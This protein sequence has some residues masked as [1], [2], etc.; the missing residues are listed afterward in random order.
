MRKCRSF[1]GENH[2][3]LDC[4]HH[5][6]AKCL[7]CMYLLVDIQLRLGITVLVKLYE[8]CDCPTVKTDASGKPFDAKLNYT[9]GHVCPV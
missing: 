7:T 2:D 8:S 3:C 4:L 5:V 6:H 9:I 1:S